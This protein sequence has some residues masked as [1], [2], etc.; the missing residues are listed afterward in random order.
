[1]PAKSE[2]EMFFIQDLSVET[3]VSITEIVPWQ[4]QNLLSNQ[5]EKKKF[6]FLLKKKKMS[7]ICLTWGF[8]TSKWHKILILRAWNVGQLRVQ[9][10][11]F[12][13]FISSFTDTL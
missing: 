9:Y 11:K 1:M 4:K 2:W 10:N 7:L 12:D 8:M 3:K 6:Y 13:I 5:G